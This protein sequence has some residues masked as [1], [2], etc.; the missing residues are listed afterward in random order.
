ME[1]SFCVI[2]M[3]IDIAK[4][5]FEVAVLPGDTRWDGAPGTQTLDAL[6]HRCETLHPD[7]I[8]CEATGGYELRVVSALGRPACPSR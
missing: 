6:V 3:G 4:D 5:S 2:V 1:K 8:V 7:L